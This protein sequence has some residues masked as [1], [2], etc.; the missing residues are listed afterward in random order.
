MF[1]PPPSLVSLIYSIT[2]GLMM[3]EHVLVLERKII[4]WSRLLFV[5]AWSYYGVTS[6]LGL[7]K[8]IEKLHFRSPV[9]AAGR[10]VIME[11]IGLRRHYVL[12][13]SFLGNRKP[14]LDILQLRNSFVTHD[15]DQNILMKFTSSKAHDLIKLEKSFYPYTPAM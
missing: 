15:W 2:A 10:Q 9:G 4:N 8:T 7:S 11:G 3:S 1:Q 5:S 6:G 12:W 13:R 14:N